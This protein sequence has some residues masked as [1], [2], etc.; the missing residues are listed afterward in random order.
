MW[1]FFFRPDGKGGGG[2]RG[3]WSTAPEKRHSSPLAG[4]PYL[5]RLLD[6]ARPGDDALRDGEHLRKVLK[7][8]VPDPSSVAVLRQVALPV[9]LHLHEQHVCVLGGGQ[10]L[11]RHGTTTAR[12]K[13]VVGNVESQRYGGLVGQSAVT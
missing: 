13:C 11:S 8:D 2:S 7:P 1:R 10:V 5:Q 4:V 12:V 9:L 6:R 3:D